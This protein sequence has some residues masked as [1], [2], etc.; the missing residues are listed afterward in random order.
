MGSQI[1]LLATPK[2]VDKNLATLKASCNLLWCKIPVKMASFKD[3]RSK[4]S[5]FWYFAT[6]FR[7]LATLKRV[8]TPC[9]RTA[10]VNKSTFQCSSYFKKINY[11]KI[12]YI[13]QSKI[14]AKLSTLVKLLKI[15]IKVTFILGRPKIKSLSLK[16]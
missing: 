8:A 11:Y 16:I 1:F 13:K 15:D 7:S 9:M 5:I 2:L 6:H 3:I 10:A 4:N 14:I 12:Q